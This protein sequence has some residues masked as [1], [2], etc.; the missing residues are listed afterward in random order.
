MKIYTPDYY[1]AFQ[2]IAGACQHSCCVGW[3]IVL[4]E[5][6]F[7]RYCKE[8]V[9]KKHVAT[10]DG[11]PCIIQQQDGRCP[12][13]NADN[14]CDVILKYGEDAIG[15]ICT[16]H[17]RFRHDYQTHTEMGL[18]L[19]CEAVCD[20]VLNR[21]EKTQFEMP[22]ISALSKREQAF[23][24]LRAELIGMAQ[25]REFSVEERMENILARCGVAL[26]D[27]NW[28][29]MFL[30]LERLDSAWDACVEALGKDKK[31]TVP[32]LQAE[33]LLV[34]FL[35]RHLSGALEDGRYLERILFCALSTKVVCDIFAGTENA[36]G[37]IARMYSAEIEYSEQNTEEIL[38][39]LSE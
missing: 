36:F 29:E 16:D 12:F 34:Y 24:F 26:P 4:D 22:D 10:K 3:E 18:G 5:A 6:T 2:C 35:Y 28:K 33:Q 11:V 23:F 31:R 8:E 30:R 21:K 14:L 27:R 32:Q 1:S 38:E 37:D 9:L 19:C 15:Q 25:N 17:P 7:A 13:L 20:L 39:A